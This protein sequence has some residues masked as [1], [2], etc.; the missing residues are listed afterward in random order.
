MPTLI[1]ST[2]PGQTLDIALTGGTPMQTRCHDT[3]SRDDRGDEVVVRA[4]ERRVGRAKWT[5]N[6]NARSVSACTPSERPEEAL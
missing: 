4:C 5:G 3:R 2:A 6:V 1:G